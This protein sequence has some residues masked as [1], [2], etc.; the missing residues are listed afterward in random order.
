MELGRI[1]GPLQILLTVLLVAG[2][3]GLVFLAEVDRS[4]S[5]A[6][7]EALNASDSAIQVAGATA[8]D[9]L[10]MN[11]QA[12]AWLVGVASRRDVQIS[13]VLLVGV[14]Y[15]AL[16]AVDQGAHSPSQRRCQDF[17]GRRESHGSSHL[18]WL[19]QQG[20]CWHPRLNISKA[21]L[22]APL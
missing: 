9:S 10:S 14:G 12:R 2:L 19:A 11:Q 3:A 1:F 8:R 6:A 16:D 20:G 18:S 4:E 22:C 17:K 7:T 5:Q 15:S 13:R 21:L